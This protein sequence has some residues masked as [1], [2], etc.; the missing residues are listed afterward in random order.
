M[1][2]LDNAATTYPKPKCVADAVSRALTRFGG[3]PGRGSHSMSVRS[4]SMIGEAREEI[5]RL[6]D[7]PSA[8]G[9]VFTL[10]TTH[11]LNTAIKASVRRGDHVLISSME[12]NSVLR[13]VS[14]LAERGVISFDVFDAFAPDTLAAIKAKMRRETSL[15]VCAHASNVCES[16]LP[17]GEIG[18]FLKTCGVRFIVDAAQSAGKYPISLRSDCIDALCVPGHKGLYG[19]MGCGALVVGEGF[20]ADGATLVEG[21]SGINS[22]DLH[23]PGFLPERFEAGT[24]PTPAIA[25]LLAG[26][27]F[28]RSVGVDAIAAHEACLA[29][30]VASRLAEMPRVRL[31]GYGGANVSKGDGGVILF[32]VDG[33]SAPRVC[34]MLD[35]EGICVRGGFHCSPLAH[36]ALGTGDDGAVRASFGYFNTRSDALAL[37]DA[38]R[39]I[40][41][42]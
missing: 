2:Y 12:H 13:P 8:D 31:Y 36:R 27:R 10:N 33:V 14:A 22:L 38:V 29:G 15:V 30:E 7:A 40:A 34:E 21:G 16:V 26:V 39:R 5:A 32:N 19:P 17:I 35:G 9:V 24:L 4:A 23:M 25:G 37:C 20:A 3:N 18:A 11:A 41:K 6:F 1:I 42:T 28:V